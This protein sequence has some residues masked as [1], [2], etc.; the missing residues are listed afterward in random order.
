M[1]QKPVYNAVRL[2]KLQATYAGNIESVRLNSQLDNGHLVALGS[3]EDNNREV[4]AAATPTAVA[5]QELVFIASPETS[6]DQTDMIVNFT[7]QA[8]K[9]ARGYHFTVGDIVTITD[10]VIDGTSVKDQYLVPQNNSNKWSASS[11]VG[12]SRLVAQVVQKT[13]L[14]GGYPATK[15]KIIKA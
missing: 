15:I 1:I 14:Y 7:N 6:Y 3:V 4:F 5:T 8:G 12:S 9:V 11:S 13:T 10:G 2:D